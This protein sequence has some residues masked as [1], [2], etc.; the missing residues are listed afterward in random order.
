MFYNQAQLQA[1]PEIQISGDQANLSGS[2]Q[3]QLQALNLYNRSI[4]FYIQSFLNIKDDDV[5]EII[6]LNL[7]NFYKVEHLSLSFYKVYMQSPEIKNLMDIFLEYLINIKEF[8]LKLY[9]SN[10]NK[11]KLDQIL[12]NLKYFQ[13]I[14]IVNM[15]C[16]EVANTT[17][18][19][20]AI[21]LQ[22]LKNLKNIQFQ[23][24]NFPQASSIQFFEE[25]SKIQTIKEM[26]L[27]FDDN[28]LSN[29]GMK[30]LGNMLLQLKQLQKLHLSLRQCKLSCEGL[31]FL[32]QGVSEC[33]T[34]NSLYI[35]ITNNS[36]ES[37]FL[38][39]FAVEIKKWNHLN[40]LSLIL[41]YIGCDQK[42]VNA[43]TEGFESLK[44]MRYFKLHISSINEIFYSRNQQQKDL[45]EMKSFNKFMKSFSNIIQ[46]DIQINQKCFVSLLNQ[47]KYCESIQ[48]LS[49]SIDLS[50]QSESI[51]NYSKDQIA[52]ALQNL[53]NIENINIFLYNNSH[54]NQI[55]E[56][57]Q[58]LIISQI[59]SLHSTSNLCLDFKIKR[60]FIFNN[61]QLA[62][63]F[64]QYIQQYIDSLN[65]LQNSLEHITLNFGYQKVDFLEISSLKK[66]KNL[67]TLQFYNTHFSK[68]QIQELR[69]IK[70]LVN[71]NYKLNQ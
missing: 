70:R 71:I 45:L 64:L 5:Y 48:Y 9:K 20:I 2:L 44:K 15:E 27:N 4:M 22:Q 25:L 7:K 18:K 32:G 59:K 69:K 47:L 33:K 60:Q 46:L 35:D 42:T 12:T 62:Q 10:L 30:A 55:N 17:P 13:N 49:F 52:R 50:E 36:L 26:K 34:L 3:A 19:Q 43:F 58:N 63:P 56:D 41:P 39:E 67:K 11:A 8:T 65:H 28:C 23:A 31:Q 14:E 57:L 66:I 61:Q 16:S 6:K 1:L 38:F 21:N 29:G 54:T 37:K 51:L 40:Q 68:K 24:C 53:E